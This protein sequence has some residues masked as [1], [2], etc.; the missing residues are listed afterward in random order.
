MRDRRNSKTY[1]LLSL[2]IATLGLAPLVNS[3]SNPRIATLHSIDI[4]QLTAVGWCF[5]LS[6]AFLIVYFRSTSTALAER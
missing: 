3:M 4:L 2:I 1:L 5:G 6:A